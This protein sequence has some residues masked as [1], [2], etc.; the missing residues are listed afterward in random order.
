MKRAFAAVFALILITGISWSWPPDVTAQD[1]TES[2]TCGVPDEGSPAVA[3]EFGYYLSS[4]PWDTLGV[5]E[6]E[7]VEPEEPIASLTYPTM[8]N[9]YIV[10]R[11]RDAH[12][13]WGPWRSS[14]EYHHDLG[15]PGGCG[16][17]RKVTGR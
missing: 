14:E 5:Y 10:A 9:L 6:V 16:F 3:Y 17:I 8:T 1:V 7:A 12:M 15:A 4:A 13:R 11:A 2:W